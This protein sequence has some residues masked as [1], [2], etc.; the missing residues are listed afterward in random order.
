MLQQ[1]LNNIGTDLE[2]FKKLVDE[3]E[4]ASIH[5]QYSNCDAII[6]SMLVSLD[7][8]ICPL[9]VTLRLIKLWRQLASLIQGKIFEKTLQIWLN[10]P[11]AATQD[12][13]EINHSVL[14]NETPT[15]MFRVDD[16]IFRSPPHF[17]VLIGILNFY[18]VV[19]K[20]YNEERLSKSELSNPSEK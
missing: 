4:T 10:S 17:E 3:L 19:V 7:S 11:R 15:L 18:L 16:R 9:D 13:V 14:L 12:R 5:E 2:T 1:A 6:Q 8:D 20:N